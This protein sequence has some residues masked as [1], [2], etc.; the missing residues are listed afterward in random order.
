MQKFAEVFLGEGGSM[1]YKNVTTLFFN[2]TGK[3]Y[4]K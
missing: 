1:L 4:S 2:L 3:F